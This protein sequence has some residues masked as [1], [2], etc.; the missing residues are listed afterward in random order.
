MEASQVSAAAVSRAD[1]G[2]TQAAGSLRF[3]K[4]PLGFVSSLL[5]KKP[6]RRQGLLMVMTGAWLVYAVAQRRLRQQVV[7]QNQTVPHQIHHPTHRP[8]LRWVCQLLEGIHR[9][10]VT[11]QGHVHDLIEGLNEV[12]ITIRRLFG[13]GVCRLYQIS[14]GSGCSMSALRLDRHG[15]RRQLAFGSGATPCGKPRLRVVAQT[16]GCRTHLRLVGAVSSQQQRL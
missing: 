4:D 3:L 9:V 8:T 15:I 1:K 13:E 10:R 6:S 7:R 12:Q 16:L 5:V 2:Q 14:P 11:V